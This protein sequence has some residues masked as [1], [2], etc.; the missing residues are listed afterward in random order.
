MTTGL[1][2]R[3]N[4]VVD[5]G[6]LP[7]PEPLADGMLQEPHFIDAVATLRTRFAPFP[8]AGKQTTIVSGN[9]FIYYDPDNLNVRLGPDCF[10]AF[11]VEADAIRAQ[12]GYL[13]WQV[14]K[15]PDFVLKIASVSTAQRDLTVKR[16]LYAAIG[17][18]E[19][20]RF[21]ST[22]GSHYG[23]PLVGEYLSDGEYRRLEL[24]PP[25]D[26]GT[27]RGYS[28]ALNLEI[29]WE[30]GRLFFHDPTTGE[31]LRNPEA[32]E[33]RGDE[34]VARAERAESRVQELEAELRRLR[35]LR[36]E[37]PTGGCLGLM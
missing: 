6:S 35:G 21:D 13:L 28:P 34:A 19:Y 17:V 14:G 9:Q 37:W 3:S 16:G 22:G 2:R 7:D 11:D 29:R 23:E 24:E 26:E 15:A 32:A 12:N 1:D 5:P 4:P 31:R 30:E 33:A 18:G 10:V 27:V 8:G 36:E 20:W 25:T